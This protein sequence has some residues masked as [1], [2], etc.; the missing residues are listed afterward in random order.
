[1]SFLVIFIQWVYGSKPWGCFLYRKID[2]QVFICNRNWLLISYTI[3]RYLHYRLS[4][5]L[6]VQRTVDSK[7]DFRPFRSRCFLSI[8]VFPDFLNI[9]TNRI[10]D[11]IG[12]NSIRPFC[13]G[14]GAVSYILL[15][16]FQGKI[17]FTVFARFILQK[18]FGVLA[19][20]NRGFCPTVFQFLAQ[21]II[22]R[23]RLGECYR[24]QI[25]RV[26]LIQSYTLVCIFPGVLAV[27]RP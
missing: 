8:R 11:C 15:V 5:H 9:I 23:H 6:S 3:Q 19:L 10:R 20:V 1:M 17:L 4:C 13:F 18:V 2:S 24:T 21:R 26:K 27:F 14:I 12:N 7:G 22:L 16:L 25:F